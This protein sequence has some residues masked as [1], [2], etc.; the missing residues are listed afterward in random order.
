MDRGARG[1]A[2]RARCR[3]LADGLRLPEPFSAAGLAGVVAAARGR[4]LELIALAALEWTPCG[5]LIAT[6]HADYIGYPAAATALHSQHIVLHEISHLLCGHLDSR[7]A[8]AELPPAL[9]THVP[10][11]LVRRVLGRSEYDDAQEQ[12]AEVLASLI[13]LRAGAARGPAAAGPG[14]GDSGLDVLAALLGTERGRGRRSRR[15]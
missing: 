9:L 8:G 4:P 12:E 11:G 2:L 5:V 7:A 3:N 10:P 1:R 13:A 14:P 15:G 6:D